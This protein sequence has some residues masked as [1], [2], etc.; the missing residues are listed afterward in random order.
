M[1]PF[2]TVVIVG[3]SFCK[4][5]K[6]STDWPVYLGKLLQCQVLGRGWGGCAWWSTRNTLLQTKH[7]KS[8]S[9]LI[10]IHTEPG[11]LP[12]DFN[13]PANPGLLFS[14]PGS[15]SD[16]FKNRKVLRD[17][18]LAFYNSDLFSL[19]FYTWAAQAWIKELDADTEYYATVHIPAFDSVELSCVKNGV[20]VQPSQDHISLRALS[21]REVDD[22]KWS[23][24]DTRSNHL[25]D[26]NNVNL[27]MA[28][29]DIIKS[30]Q[31]GANGVRT[32]HNLDHWDFTH[33]TFKNQ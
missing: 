4:D 9:I 20:V 18:A 30:I 28:L 14:E 15:A 16:E 7:N 23:G 24:P 21:N 12:N 3:D 25:K 22:N 32:F 29:F 1:K 11:R 31:P 6:R 19:K 10:V 13:I 17:T 26:I 5:R 27:A 2:D 8:T 33:Q